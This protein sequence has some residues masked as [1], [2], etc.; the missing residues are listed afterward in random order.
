MNTDYRT[1]TNGLRDAASLVREARPAGRGEKLLLSTL[2]GAIE[3]IADDVEQRTGEVTRLERD[4]LKAAKAW[5][6]DRFGP[7]ELENRLTEAIA[8]LVEAESIQK[9]IVYGG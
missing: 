8:A 7:F 9:E 5:R 1:Y 4:V 6:A 2:A 3:K